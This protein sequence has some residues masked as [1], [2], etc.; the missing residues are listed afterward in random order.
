MLFRSELVAL[1]RRINDG[2]VSRAVRSIELAIGALGDQPVLVLGLTYREGVKE[3]AYSRA[4]PLI[5]HLLVAGAHVLAHDP[6]L[7]D[8]EVARLGATPWHWGEASAAR[9]IVTQTADPRWASLDPAWFPDLAFVYDGR[10]SLADLRLPAHVG[11]QGV[12]LPPGARS[13]AR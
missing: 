2:Q 11:Y 12:G 3:M 7:A 8:E 13:A 9:V 4:V 5:E 6:L 10:N 1:S